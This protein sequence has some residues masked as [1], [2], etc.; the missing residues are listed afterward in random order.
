MT[1]IFLVLAAGMLLGGV[2]ALGAGVWPVRP[3]IAGALLMIGIAIAVRRRWGLLAETAPGSPERMLWVTLATHTVVAAHLFATLYRIGPAMVMHTPVVHALG[4]DSWTLVGGALVAYW[5][6]RDPNPRADERDG[7][8]AARG[9]RAA[10]LG[11]LLVLAVQILVLGFVHEGWVAQLSRP[12]IA[13]ALILAI[14]LSVLVDA[15]TRL[16]AY[17]RD[18]E[19]EAAEAARP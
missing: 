15:V 5:I 12:T 18:A 17:A 2:L 16:L 13:H 1:R 7:A 14:I 19:A 9:M 4:M 8:I 10:Y 6:V 11:L 3:G